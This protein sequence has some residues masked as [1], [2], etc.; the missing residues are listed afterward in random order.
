MRGALLPQNVI[1]ST[2]SLERK[3]EVCFLFVRVCASFA[4]FVLLQVT[5]ARGT[6][7]NKTADGLM[8]VY[9]G[10]TYFLIALRSQ[11]LAFCQVG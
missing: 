8:F 2:K 10:L 4:H 5:P 6:S 1:C 3:A 7:S 9:A 11:T